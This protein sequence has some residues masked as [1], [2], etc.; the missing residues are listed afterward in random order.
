[1]RPDA[2]T[3]LTAILLLA[4]CRQGG[5]D[6]DGLDPGETDP[7]VT[8]T[9]DTDGSCGDGVVQAPEECDEGAHNG[10]GNCLADCT[11]AQD[12]R[13]VVR[14]SDVSEAGLTP[15]MTGVADPAAPLGTGAWSYQGLSAGEKLELFVDPEEPRASMLGALTMGDLV[16]F[17]YATRAAPS[18]GVQEVYAVLYTKPTGTD[19]QGGF[20]HHR[21][22]GEPAY[23]RA[24]TETEG[25]TTWS[26]GGPDDQLTWVDPDRTGTFGYASGQPTWTELLAGPFDWSTVDDTLDP[27]SLDYAAE[28]LR[29]LS[30]QTA[31]GWSEGRTF[32]LDAIRLTLASGRT[33]TVDLEPD[34]P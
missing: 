14:P 32:H 25:W 3:T 12:L 16:S 28:P 6:E 17:S 30:L 20:Y 18:E 29:Y 9:G 24:R 19:D 1:M 2:R 33:I 27:T 22:I 10:T 11:W 34:T 21:L 8:D 26:T 4:A 23:A 31:S 13:F 7:P 5:K 15:P